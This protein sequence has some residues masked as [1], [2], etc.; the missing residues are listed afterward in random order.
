MKAL[1][2]I[3]LVWAVIQS[4]PADLPARPD[5]TC[6][7][8]AG[9]VTMRANEEWTVWSAG[10]RFVAAHYPTATGPGEPDVPDYAVFGW[11]ERGAYVPLLAMKWRA[12]QDESACPWLRGDPA[13]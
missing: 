1:A 3:L 10:S 5:T 8:L 6:K 2:T 7:G 11:I 4:P 13:K 9:P 12:V